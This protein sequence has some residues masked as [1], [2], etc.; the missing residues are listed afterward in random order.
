L[1]TQDIPGLGSF[2]GARLQCAPYYHPWGAEG[3]VH[4]SGAEIVP[5]STYVV[6]QL[7]ASCLGIEQGCAAVSEPLIISTARHGDIAP[8][9]NPPNPANQP[10]AVDVTYL[11]NKFR[12]LPGAPPKVT[13]QLQPNTPDPNSNINALDIAVCVDAFR[14]FAY[15]YTGPCP[16]PSAVPCNVTVCGAPSDC[17]A[18]HGAGAACVKSCASGPRSGHPCNNGLHCGSCSAASANPGIPCD[19]D[20]DCPSGSC[21]TGLCGLGFCRDRCAR[22]FP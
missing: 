13:A 17:T 8:P 21:D 1:E 12:N 4:V 20:A 6:E 22:C 5:S 18:L 19:A 2:R 9:L 16:C 7:A 14:G 15:S 11:V 3:L 10:D